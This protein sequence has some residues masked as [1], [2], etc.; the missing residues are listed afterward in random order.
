[1]AWTSGFIVELKKGLINFFFFL[2]TG[3][4]NNSI[5]VPSIVGFKIWS[6]PLNKEIVKKGIKKINDILVIIIINGYDWIPADIPK[7]DKIRPEKNNW[8]TIDKIPVTV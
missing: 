3:S 1:M 2:E 7:K 6:T 4:H 8:S 5:V